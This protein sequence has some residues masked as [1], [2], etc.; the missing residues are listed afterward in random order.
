MEDFMNKITVVFSM[1]FLLIFISCAGKIDTAGKVEF[2]TGDVKIAGNAAVQEMA[3]S[4]GY[5][6]VT[7]KDSSCEIVFN[8]KNIIRIME[9]SDIIFNISSIKKELKVN[10]GAVESVLRNLNPDKNKSAEPFTIDTGTAVAAVRGTSFYVS[11]DKFSNTAICACNGVVEME[12]PGGTNKYT[13]ESPHHN[14]FYYSRTKNGWAYQNVKITVKDDA[15]MKRQAG[16]NDAE[17]ESLAA[18]IGEKIDWT[19][20][21]RK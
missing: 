16:H 6:V 13:A 20:V 14:G 18:K 17:M 11:V 15:D 8:E 4:N 1:F 21:D 9:N 2:F 12:S 5:E 3:V 10:S 19:K 7:G